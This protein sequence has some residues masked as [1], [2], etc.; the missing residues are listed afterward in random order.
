MK[1]SALAANLAVIFLVASAYTNCA[2]SIFRLD[3]TSNLGNPMTT[4]AAPH[5][6]TAVCSVL[7]RCNAAVTMSD[8]MRGVA[9]TNGLGERLGLPPGTFGA[10]GAVVSAEQQGDITANP[11]TTNGCLADINVLACASPEVTG[12]YDSQAPQPYAG[13]AAMLNPAANSCGGIFAG[14][15]IFADGFESGDASSFER[16]SA[17]S[18]HPSTGSVPGGCHSGAFCGAQTLAPGVVDVDGNWSKEVFN[19]PDRAYVRA[20]YKFPATWQFTSNGDRDFTVMNLSW[21]ACLDGLAIAYRSRG[22]AGTVA[23]L[24][25]YSWTTDTLVHRGNA[26]TVD[27]L[28]HS[29]EVHASPAQQRVQVWHD[30]VKVIDVADRAGGCAAGEVRFGAYVNPNGPLPKAETFYLDDIVISKDQ[31]GP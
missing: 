27:G 24:V 29:I 19:L 12:A 2:P 25:A 1:R 13:V 28:W 17:T 7:N 21:G 22:G 14:S 3:G 15:V 11:I 9:S 8:C 26:Y 30:G 23:D 5:V 10:F 6:Q 16:S 4:Q 20:Y 31:V 18:S